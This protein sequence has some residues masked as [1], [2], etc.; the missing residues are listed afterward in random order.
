MITELILNFHKNCNSCT[1][2]LLTSLIDNLE[3]KKKYM[4]S[5]DISMHFNCA[6]FCFFN[7]ICKIA[8]FVLYVL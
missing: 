5:L 4:K 1:N 3:A 6:F 8:I 2:C 7:V